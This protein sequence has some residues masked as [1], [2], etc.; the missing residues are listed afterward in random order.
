MALV[1]NG[2]YPHLEREFVNAATI[3]VGLLVDPAPWAR[4]HAPYGG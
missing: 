1:A 2:L 4:K 3:L